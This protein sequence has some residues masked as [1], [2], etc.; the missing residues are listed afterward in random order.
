M[1]KILSILLSICLLF[2]F[3]TFA[4]TDVEKDSISINTLSAL[5]IIEGFEDGS[6]RPEDTITRAE[7]VKI[8]CEILGYHEVAPTETDFTDVPS[9]HWASGYIKIAC[10]LGIVEGHGDGTFGPDDAVSYEQVV[11][12]IV[13]A[14]GYNPMA[15]VNGGYP[16][17]YLVV[18]AQRNILA[19]TASTATRGNVAQM[20]YNA[21][22]VPMMGQTSF[23]TE[24]SYT[25]TENTLL[26]KLNIVKFEGTIEQTSSSD[27]S[28]K[29][30]KVQVKYEKQY[31][32]TKD[33]YTVQKYSM[34]KAETEANPSDVYGSFTTDKKYKKATINVAEGLSVDEYLDYNVI[35]FVKDATDSDATLVAVSPKESKNAEVSFNSKDYYANKSKTEKEDDL[36]TG[37]IAVYIDKDNEKSE[38]YD[39][40][41]SKVYVNGR[42]QTITGVD[43]K[44]VDDMK[45]ILD[46]YLDDSLDVDIKLVRNTSGDEYNIVYITDYQDMVVETINKKTTTLVGKADLLPKLVIDEDEYSGRYSIQS[47]DGT[48]LTFDDIKEDDTLT[49]IGYFN[50]NRE[51]EY[52]TIIV[53][54]EKVSGKITSFNEEDKTITIDDEVYDYN[55]VIAEKLENNSIKL[56][57]EMTFYVNARGYVVAIDK[58]NSIKN[59]KYGFAT[60]LV[61]STGIKDAWQIRVLT[62]DGIWKTFD[63]ASKVSLNGATAV[64]ISNYDAD[65]LT[66]EIGSNI[67]SSERLNINSIIA[68]E[69]N[70]SDEIKTLYGVA[71]ENNY[72]A[73]FN[74]KKVNGEYIA[75][76][77]SI[78][79]V[80]FDSNT[81]VYSYEFA[82]GA[83]ELDEDDITVGTSSGLINRETYSAFAYGL[84][85]ENYAKVLCGAGILT[86]LSFA[87]DFFTISSKVNTTNADGD[88][89]YL[90]T[91]FVKG[92]E[93]SIFADSLEVVGASE[94]SKG[95]VIIY[96]ETANG[97][98]SKMEILVKDG[99]I[100]YDDTPFATGGNTYELIS[101]LAIKRSGNTL[102]IRLNDETE[103]SISLKSTLAG[104]SVDLFASKVKVSSAIAGDIDID[105]TNDGKGDIIFARVKNDVLVEDYVIFEYED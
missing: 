96:N 1:R 100:L 99:V 60:K 104:A 33:N 102:T 8:I 3:T 55:N 41:I 61:K 39:I 94:V 17:G 77:D 24:I 84:D 46:T 78:S 43:I 75:A 30:G 44:T 92:E 62:T 40:S 67:V 73:T 9:T 14:L 89:G 37:T 101:G 80:F 22:D 11:K 49:I 68:Y 65:A 83:V 15:D 26:N 23:G 90:F 87:N 64:S 95:D 28:I 93:V 76:I 56:G 51:F 63:F 97:E 57:D 5:D 36:I 105:N 50:S 52:G 81:V 10:G 29:E 45:A 38:K 34:E 47:V 7:I 85:D 20:I 42:Q 16:S 71:V 32:A 19:D 35:M 66:A 53:S 18:A 69:T 25:A 21:L 74:Y 91:G 82:D 79:S 31:S 98:I 72:D 59:L 48:L 4:Y 13:A 2:S 86:N 58:T 88:E 27:A 54:S 103:R 12:M 70:S 6:F